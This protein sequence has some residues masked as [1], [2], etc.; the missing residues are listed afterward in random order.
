MQRLH[1]REAALVVP[2]ADEADLAELLLTACGYREMARERPEANMPFMHFIRCP[3]PLAARRLERAWLNH[4]LMKFAD[5]KAHDRHLGLAAAGRRNLP[6]TTDD[7][8]HREPCV[9]LR[10]RVTD[11]RDAHDPA[12]LPRRSPSK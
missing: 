10:C 6:P 2:E 9:G 12:P 8:L 5:E 11:D 7:R 3:S 1:P 4:R